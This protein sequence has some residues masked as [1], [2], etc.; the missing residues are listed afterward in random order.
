MDSAHASPK[1]RRCAPNRW[2]RSAGYKGETIKNYFINYHNLHC[3]LTVHLRDGNV[4]VHDGDEEDWTV[5]L[6]DTGLKTETGGRI[7]RLAPIIGQE[8]FM[9]TYGDGVASINIRDL[10]QFHREQGRL[11][12]V[13]AVRPP[14]RFGG[15]VLSNHH[16][17][18]FKE[19]PQVGEGWING[20][21]FVLEPQIL[22]AIEGDAVDW[23]RE[24]LERLVAE[25]QLAAYRHEGFWQCMD[26]LR[27]VRLLQELWQSGKAPWKLWN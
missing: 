10:V 17:V 26:T 14:A 18:D 16:V 4:D 7:K 1:K 6:V 3:D 21:F 24:S 8:P 11:A 19:K 13:T 12:T 27:D 5:H 9:L 23:E 20:G 15:M 25:N 22:D 2:W